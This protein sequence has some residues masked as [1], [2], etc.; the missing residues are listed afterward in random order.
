MLGWLTRFAGR[1]RK[2]APVAP[3]FSERTVVVAAIALSSIPGSTVGSSLPP[4]EI[5]RLLNRYLDDVLGIVARTGGTCLRHVGDAVLA[6]WP[7]PTNEPEQRALGDTVL[8]LVTAVKNHSTPSIP[9]RPIIGLGHGSVVHSTHHLGGRAVHLELG[10]AVNDAQRLCSACELKKAE[11]L[12]FAGL[13]I[14]WPAH[15]K[16][17]ELERVFVKGRADQ[18]LL[19]RVVSA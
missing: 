15:G 3:S 13:P 1:R 10:A 8:A 7:S 16:V 12:F 11:I 4:A 2:V 17:E 18:P 6:E 9:L 19:C 5:V 14:A